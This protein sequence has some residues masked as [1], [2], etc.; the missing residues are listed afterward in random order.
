MKSKSETLGLSLLSFVIVVVVSLIY[1]QW[2]GQAAAAAEDVAAYAYPGPDVPPTDSGSICNKWYADRLGLPPGSE[3]RAPEDKAYAEC[4]AARHA[5]LPGPNAKPRFPLPQAQPTVL[6][7]NAQRVAGQ[8]VIVD[9]SM[10]ITAYDII[11]SW[12]K[13]TSDKRIMVFAGA[14]RDDTSGGPAS[15]VQGVVEIMVETADYH[16]LPDEGGMYPTP[17]R[18]G[19]VRIVDANGMQL[20][21]VAQDGTGFFF[22]VAS[23]KYVFPGPQGIVS[24]AAGKGVISEART[25]PFSIGEY[26]FENQWSEQLGNKRVTVWAGAESQDTQ[27]GVVA[28]VVTDAGKGGALLSKDIYLT[29]VKFGAVRVFDAQDGQITLSSP[30]GG[31]F[32]FDVSTRQFTTWPEVPPEIGVTVTSSP[33]LPTAKL[34]IA[35]P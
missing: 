7:N 8:G 27:Q 4:V 11:N 29:P 6:A 12:H 18:A 26:V 34:L 31:R 21:L 25:S 24:R 16:V 1:M 28:V 9:D 10:P 13:E 30:G 5:P 35:Y 19:A 20:T 33:P 3:K 15:T 14:L 32:V 17:I 2:V 23:R 22:D